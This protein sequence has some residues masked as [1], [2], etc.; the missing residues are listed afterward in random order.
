MAEFAIESSI[1]C[2]GQSQA[3]VLNPELAGITPWIQRHIPIDSAGLHVYTWGYT[4]VLSDYHLAGDTISFPEEVIKSNTLERQLPSPALLH[5]AMV[6]TD[7]LSLSLPEDEDDGTESQDKLDMRTSTFVTQLKP[8]P[9]QEETVGLSIQLD[10]LLKK[11]DC[12]SLTVWDETAIIQKQSTKLFPLGSDVYKIVDAEH[13]SANLE[14][15]KQKMSTWQDEFFRRYLVSSRDQFQ[16]AYDAFTLALEAEEQKTE[17]D[18]GAEIRIKKLRQQQHTNACILQALN[19]VE[20]SEQNKKLWQQMQDD[21]FNYDGQLQEEKPVEFLKYWSETSEEDRNRT[22]AKD[23]FHMQM[24]DFRRQTTLMWTKGR[25]SYPRLLTHALIVDRNVNPFRGLTCDTVTSVPDMFDVNL[26]LDY[27]NMETTK[28]HLGS[29]PLTMTDEQYRIR[30]NEVLGIN[31]CDIVSFEHAVYLINM[32]KDLESRPV[33]VPW[34]YTFQ[35]MVSLL[36]YHGTPPRKV[37]L[38]IDCKKPLMENVGACIDGL[39]GLTLENIP[40]REALADKGLIDNDSGDLDPKR[41]L[42]SRWS[43]GGQTDVSSS[44]QANTKANPLE[45]VFSRWESGSTGEED[46]PG[47]SEWTVQT[48]AEPLVSVIDLINTTAIDE[49][50]KNSASE[51][52]EEGEEKEEDRKQIQKSCAIKH[53]LLVTVVV[54]NK[55]LNALAKSHQTLSPERFHVRLRNLRDTYRAMDYTKNSH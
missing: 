31:M 21:V 10:G 41:M 29:K 40:W 52:A 49:I 13:G 25:I 18:G 42:A 35:V 30:A 3:L 36:D 48:Y 2:M 53:E 26:I 20:G 27:N 33:I 43:T 54:C 50:Q 14:E 44:S 24:N 38:A 32:E 12:S 34:V 8:F 11:H 16:R 28:Q 4:G 22:N 15:L 55:A 51:K 37:G 9:D 5:L 17:Q 6:N 46:M 1:C 47:V 23:R 7:P 39:A 19:D 45:S